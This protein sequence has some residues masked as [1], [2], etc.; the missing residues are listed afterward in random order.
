[1][2]SKDKNTKNGEETSSKE[3]EREKA[4]KEGEEVAGWWADQPAPPAATLSSDRSPGRYSGV[5]PKHAKARSVNVDL[6]S[7]LD[8]SRRPNPTL[9]GAGRWREEHPEESDSEGENFSEEQL[10]LGSRKVPGEFERYG[11]ERAKGM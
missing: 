9:V 8:A 3:P 11:E 1:M 7:L 6:P 4:S 10:R 5:I 2:A